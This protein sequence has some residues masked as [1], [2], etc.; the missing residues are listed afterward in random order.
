MSLLDVTKLK[1]TVLKQTNK[2]DGYG[3]YN[4][5]WIDEF[6]FEG[7]LYVTQNVNRDVADKAE[8]VDAYVLL[9]PRNIAIDFHDVIRVDS[10]IYRGKTFRV[11]TKAD[12]DFTPSTATLDLK[13]YSMQEWAAPL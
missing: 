1:F 9:T 5:I 12:E 8:V 11:T 3:G 10:G 13:K 7:N 6:S 2:P 4:A